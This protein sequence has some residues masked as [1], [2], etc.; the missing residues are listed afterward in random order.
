M[1]RGLHSDRTTIHAESFMDAT[2]PENSKT[3]QDETYKLGRVAG[4][5]RRSKATGACTLSVEIDPRA[6]TT[7]R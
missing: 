5:T 1:L 4:G 3:F 2:E 7:H 6:P